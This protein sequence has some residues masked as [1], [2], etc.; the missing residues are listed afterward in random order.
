ML[1]NYRGGEAFEDV[2]FIKKLFHNQIIYIFIT[3]AWS[4]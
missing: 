2:E 1:L 3:G 4:A